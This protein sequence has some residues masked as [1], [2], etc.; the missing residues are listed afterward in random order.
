MLVSSLSVQFQKRDK[1]V[2]PAHRKINPVSN[3]TLEIL[4]ILTLVGFT[5]LNILQ[6]AYTI[7]TSEPP[8]NIQ[9]LL[10]LIFN[11]DFSLNRPLLF[12][13]KIWLV[14]NQVEFL[15]TKKLR[16]QDPAVK[17]YQES[18]ISPTKNGWKKPVVE[19]RMTCLYSCMT[20]YSQM[21][22]T[23]IL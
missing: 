16:G 13:E 18:A 10:L 3:C 4:G 9:P 20:D 14:R 1:H 6:L 2:L 8:V 7:W 19:I 17:L 11:F 15:E 23:E 5:S 12:S 22:S 21:L